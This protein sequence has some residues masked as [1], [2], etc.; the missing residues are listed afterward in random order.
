MDWYCSLVDHLLDERS[1]IEGKEPSFLVMQRLE[2]LVLDL[3]KNLL[4]YQMKSVGSYYRNSGLT[5][6]RELAAWDNWDADLKAITIAEE[7][8]RAASVQYNTPSS[9]TRLSELMQ[10]GDKMQ[11]TLGKIHQDLQDFISAQKQTVTDDKDSACLRDL[12]LVDPMREL[13]RLERQKDRL[14][15]IAFSWVMGTEEFISFSDWQGQHARRMLW[16][17]GSSG[18]GK[19]MLMIG[20]VRELSSRSAAFAPSVSYYFCQGTGYRKRNNATAILRGLLWMLLVQQPRLIRHLRSRHKY[21]GSS[22]FAGV[23]AFVAMSEALESMLQDPTMTP[24]YLVVDALDECDESLE[25]LV[26]LIFRSLRLSDKIRWLVSS[27]PSLDLMK[28]GVDEAL[29]E[30]D[31]QRLQGPVHAYVTYKLSELKS[32]TDYDDSVLL[33][34]LSNEICERASNTFLWAALAI[35]ELREVEGKDALDVIKNLPSGLASFY[36]YLMNK[37]E[38]QHGLTSNRCKNA[39]AAVFLAYRPLTF[40]ELGIVAGLGSPVQP[41]SIVK[42]CGSLLA[43]TGRVVQLVHQSARDYMREAY[44]EKPDFGGV[45]LTHQDIASRSLSEMRHTLRR[46]M[47]HLPGNGY[48]PRLLGDAINGSDNDPLAA[49]AYSCTFWM[50]H[51]CDASG[52]AASPKLVTG[53]EIL[54]FL[55]NYFLRWVE[56]LSLLGKLSEGLESVRLL[57]DA[58]VRC[59]CYVSQPSQLLT[60]GAL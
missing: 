48:F 60:R 41:L 5:Y 43:V 19:T 39:L 14:I 3:Y 23:N 34:E 52:I 6:F 7:A 24:A 10:N 37:V 53:D 59:Y 33:V 31:P 22:L 13:E 1:I 2:A 26:D 51:L 50:N 54:S 21:A 15:D 55:E 17:K 45:T 47:Y 49:V 44:G 27:R 38:K 36:E 28:P 4:L 11:S 16:L 29:I 57:S 30:L 56:G 46:N 18:T 8:L 40:R 12:F 32:R 25:S 58:Q 9:L 20:V 35:R 42:A